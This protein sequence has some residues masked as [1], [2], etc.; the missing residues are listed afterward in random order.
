MIYVVLVVL[1]LMTALFV[2]EGMAEA[3]RPSRLHSLGLA[4][5]L[6]FM[7]FLIR[8]IE[9]PMAELIKLDDT[10]QLVVELRDMMAK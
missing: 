9:H 6:A 3:K 10:R 2:G 8:D 5:T 4:L 1:M 7:F